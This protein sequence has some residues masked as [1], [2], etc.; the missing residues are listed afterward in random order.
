MFWT[1]KGPGVLEKL[2]VV[3]VVKKFS[4]FNGSDMFM[5]VFTIARQKSLFWSKQVQS[6]TSYPIF[7]IEKTITSRKGQKGSTEVGKV[8]VRQIQ[9]PK[10]AT[11][12][13]LLANFSK[14]ETWDS[15]ES[16]FPER[17]TL[18]CWEN[19]SRHFEET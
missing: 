7:F 12:Q 1:G 2:I 10:F 15:G 5:V 8:V 17:V 13:Q 11:P 3:Q 14:S 4:E 18:W 16:G 19:G 9:Y 6:R